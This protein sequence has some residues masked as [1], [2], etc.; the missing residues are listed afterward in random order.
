MLG[1][2]EQCSGLQS[3][4]KNWEISASLMPLH[5]GQGSAQMAALRALARNFLTFTMRKA[6]A[7]MM[8]AMTRTALRRR[9]RATR[10]AARA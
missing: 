8:T 2:P 7:R 10:P 5:T 9:A 3:G 6:N 1:R 4:R